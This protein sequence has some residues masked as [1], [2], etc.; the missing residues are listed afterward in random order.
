M[1]WKDTP[2]PDQQAIRATRGYRAHPILLASDENQELALDLL[3]HGIAGENYYAHEHNPPYF[4]AAPGAIKELYVREGVFQ[5]LMRVNSS[6]AKIDLELYVFDAYRP[7]EVQNYFH[8][9]WVPAF[10]KKRNPEWSDEMIRKEVGKYWAAGVS[11]ISDIDPLSPPPHATG[12]VVDL[13]LRQRGSGA[14]LHMGSE[15]DSVKAISYADHFEH[16]LVRRTLT[17]SEVVALNNRR[18][19]Y[20]AMSAEGFVVNPTE[21]WHFGVGDQMSAF[22]SGGSPA[23][24]SLLR[25]P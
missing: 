13:T 22:H 23:V 21:W 15:F 2:I 7:P 19:L 12:A 24:Y 4:H 1:Q 17:P 8:D 16:E 25:L 20:H 9:V 18:T 10:L 6:L 14:L 11:D 5:R 3:L